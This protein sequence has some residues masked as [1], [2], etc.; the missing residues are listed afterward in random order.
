MQSDKCS[1]SGSMGSSGK[2]SLSR[3]LNWILK[4]LTRWSRAEKKLHA[5]GW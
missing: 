2:S 4:E 5:K 1:D 3:C